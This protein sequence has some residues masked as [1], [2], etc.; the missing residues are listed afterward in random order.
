MFV[1]NVEHEFVLGDAV[2][3]IESAPE[4]DCLRPVVPI[5]RLIDLFVVEVPR[6]LGLVVLWVV[7]RPP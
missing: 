4:R 2:F 5:V 7:V 3:V 6:L 1:V